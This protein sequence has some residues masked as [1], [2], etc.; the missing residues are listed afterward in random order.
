MN[1]L[2]RNQV[3][4]NTNRLI[5]TDYHDQ[6]WYSPDGYFATAY[7][8]FKDYKIKKTQ[9]V[10]DSIM[11]RPKLTRVLPK[12][13]YIL[14]ETISNYDYT[15]IDF[16]SS[17][18][19]TTYRINKN[20]YNFLMHLYPKAKAYIANNDNEYAPVKLYDKGNFVAVIMPIIK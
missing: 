8:I 10:H 9:T 15:Y 14:A 16:G 12:C 7:P 17:K 4:K 19:Q 11:S 6:E 20:Y 5:T 2:L 3:L 18:V 13:K 1:K